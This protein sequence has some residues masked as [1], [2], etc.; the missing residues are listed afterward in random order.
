MRTIFFLII[1][2]LFSF[3]TFASQKKCAFNVSS[4]NLELTKT[5]LSKFNCKEGDRIYILMNDLQ[6]PSKKLYEVFVKNFAWN[7]CDYNK[8]ILYTFDEDSG[9]LSCIVKLLKRRGE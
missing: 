4:S 2:S 5:E 7:N 1:F 9:S 3:Q 6:V 8:Q